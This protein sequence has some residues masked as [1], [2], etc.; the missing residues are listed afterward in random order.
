MLRPLALALLALTSPAATAQTCGGL[1]AF[2]LGASRAPADSLQAS[3]ASQYDVAAVAV[4]A[5][6]PYGDV[7]TGRPALDVVADGRSVIRDTLTSGRAGLFWPRDEIRT[8]TRCG[9]ALLRYEITGHDGRTPR[10]RMTLDLYNVP[11]HVGVEAD[12][13]IPFRPGRWTY[14][15]ADDAPFSAASLRREAP[16]SR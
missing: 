1:L 16:P 2:T 5:R 10:P 9:L 11:P 12:G 4:E 7:V 13:L 15:F 6:S 3:S 14:D 8:W